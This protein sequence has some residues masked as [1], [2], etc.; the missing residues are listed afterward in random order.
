V[1][2]FF[3]DE[4]RMAMG[5]VGAKTLAELRQATV[6]HPNAQKLPFAGANA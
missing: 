5:Q 2:D 4:I 1:L 6:L 3:A